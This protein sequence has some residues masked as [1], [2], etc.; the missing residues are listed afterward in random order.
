M[1]NIC[2]LYN[3]KVKIL[4]DFYKTVNCL[5][6]LSNL[7]SQ[8]QIMKK[9]W[10]FTKLLLS[11]NH[12]V[13]AGFCNQRP[14]NFRQLRIHQLQI[15]FLAPGNFLKLPSHSADGST[16]TDATCE[17]HEVASCSI[18]F[19]QGSEHT[20]HELI[21]ANPFRVYFHARKLTIK[22]NWYSKI[23][24]LI[25]FKLIRSIQILSYFFGS[26]DKF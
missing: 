4:T 8:G 23:P 18:R 6:Y 24:N 16:H 11:L 22:N 20:W 21:K 26:I 12:L 19:N 3:H 14:G 1:F 9:I 13:T 15:R 17:G 25:F 5:F 7:P 10:S 2:R